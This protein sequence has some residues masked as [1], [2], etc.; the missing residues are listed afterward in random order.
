MSDARGWPGRPDR[1]DGRE[2]RLPRPGPGAA[3]GPGGVRAARLARRPACACAS[4]SVRAGY[5]RGPRRVA[6]R[7]VAGTGAP[8]PCPYVPRCGGCA[9]QELDYAAQLRLKAGRS[10]ASRCARAGAPWD[11]EIAARARRPRRAGALRASLHVERR[12]APALRLGLR[13]EG[14]RRVV[15]LRAL[16]AALDR[17]ESGGA[18]APRPR[19]KRGPTCGAALSGSTSP[20]RRRATSSSRPRDRARAS[21]GARAG[22][23]GGG[24]AGPHRARRAYGRTPR[25][26]PRCSAAIPFTCTARCWGARC[27]RTCASFFQGNRFLVER[28]RARGASISSRRAARCSTCTPGSACS[29]SRWPPAA[30]EVVA[31]EIDAH[32]VEDA[33]ERTPER[34]QAGAS[35]C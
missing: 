17:H 23:A 1:A 13:Q 5:A 16:P 24:G 33:R 26:I 18:G 22:V 12:R 7:A 14:T 34:G 30:T 4:T 3:R 2:G 25:A 27:A 32:A 21:G 10:C 19:S 28:A 15:D 20:S 35:G 11:G 8:S 9:Y 29:P 6:A 31:V